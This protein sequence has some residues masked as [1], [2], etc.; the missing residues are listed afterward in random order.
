MAIEKSVDI[1]N[2][3]LKLSERRLAANFTIQVALIATSILSILAGAGG[4]VE[5]EWQGRGL[6]IDI[7]ST[8]IRWPP[9]SSERVGST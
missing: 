6:R 8:P 7:A 2:D 4:A 1:Y 3:R 5:T 9:S